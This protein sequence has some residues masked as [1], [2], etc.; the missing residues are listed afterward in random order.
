LP[1]LFADITVA[2]GT[3]AENI[4]RPDGSRDLIID[5]LEFQS[6]GLHKPTVFQIDPGNRKRLP[7]CK[8][9]FVASDYV[10]GVSLVL[11][12]LAGHQQTRL[13]KCFVN[14]G[15]TFPLP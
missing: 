4:I 3:G 5:A 11:G 7:W 9:Y 14:R 15:L 6:L 10:L 13:L 1:A 2:Y 8:E 12:K